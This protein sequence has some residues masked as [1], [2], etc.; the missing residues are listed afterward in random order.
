MIEIVTQQDTAITDRRENN[1]GRQEEGKG[2]L[3]SLLLCVVFLLTRMYSWFVSMSLKR[4][5]WDSETLPL[6]AW[7]CVAIWAALLTEEVSFQAPLMLK[8][9][10]KT[11]IP[12]FSLGNRCAVSIDCLYSHG[13]HH[14]FFFFFLLLP[15]ISCSE[16]MSIPSF[17]LYSCHTAFPFISQ[18]FG[19]RS[20]IWF[21]MSLRASFLPKRLVMRKAESGIILDY[22]LLQLIRSMK[23]MHLG[24]GHLHCISSIEL[25]WQVECIIWRCHRWQHHT[26]DFETRTTF[27]DEKMGLRRDIESSVVREQMYT[28]LSLVNGFSDRRLTL[29]KLRRESTT[30]KTKSLLLPTLVIFVLRMFYN[31]IHSEYTSLY[32]SSWEYTTSS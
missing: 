18:W 3:S 8:V 27:G 4:R 24:W 30:E 2:H 9:L 22:S 13:N 17:S 29:T 26:R 32:S 25:K 12:A 20:S 28:A 31:S 21:L 14:S 16:R 15:L 11:V 7:V 23:T 1:S 5:A 19:N 10:E 6:K